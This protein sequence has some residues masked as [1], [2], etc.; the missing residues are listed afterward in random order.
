MECKLRTFQE[1]NQHLQH[2]LI[3]ISKGMS[4]GH[5]GPVRCLVF[6]PGGDKLYSASDDRSIRVWG[7]EGKPLQ[8]FEGHTDLVFCLA[9]SLDGRLYSGG[10]D[11]TIKVWSMGGTLLRTLGHGNLVTSLVLCQD[12]SKLYS[13]SC[14]GKIN[15]W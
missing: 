11:Q 7:P 1:S 9:F 8:I 4:Q 10:L 5:T 13:A 14:D 3:K 12:N 15:A 6:G 2:H